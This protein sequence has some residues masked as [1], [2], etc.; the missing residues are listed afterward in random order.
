MP[1]DPFKNLDPTQKV[2]VLP[3]HLA[4]PGLVDPRT[5]WAFPFSKGWPFAQVED[6]TAAAFSP[7]LRLQTTYGPQPHTPS[8]G[9]W[10]VSA[11]RAPSSPAVWQMR[12]D[13]TTPVELLQD[14]HIELF[15]LYLEDRHSDRD[16]LFE[17]ETAA[18]ETYVPL[19]A[20]GWNHRVKTDGTQTFL[21]ADGLAGVRHRYATTGSP[22][23]SWQV[24]G[25]HLSEPLWQARFSRGTPTTLVAALTASLIST[26]PLRRT[27][28]E[29][30]RPTRS[31]LYL[32]TPV[33]QQSPAVPPLTP[34][35][36]G[37]GTG[38]SL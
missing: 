27:A 7:C 16:R 25:G 23:P 13:A 26:E 37:P 24:W 20:R 36:P 21:A 15:D 35:P 12:F 9:T 29:V 18:Q 11:H 4:G 3:R 32:A 33:T 8:K 17:D 28:D 14:L 10:A 5:V 34:L 30:P 31:H 38:R 1:T 22:Q 2:K 6:G 19:L